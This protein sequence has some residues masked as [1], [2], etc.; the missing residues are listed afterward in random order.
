MIIVSKDIVKQ[1]YPERAAEAKKYDFGL[2]VA[3]GGSEF[4]SGPPALSALAGF[5]A[6]LDMA[7]II[8]PRRAADIIAGFSPILAAYPLEGDHLNKSHIAT[9]RSLTETAKESAHGNAAVVIGG[10]LGRSRETL[11]AVAEFLA[12]LDIPVVIDADAFYAIQKR[13]DILAG[14]PFLLTPNTYEFF[15]LTGKNVRELSHEER[16]E[17]VKTEAGKLGVTILLKLRQDIIS[18]G[19]EV[20]VNETGSPYLTVGG[21]G[22]TLAGI[23]AT[24]LA[25]GNM[26]F[27]AAQGAAYLNGRAG[28]IAA[29]KFGES[30]VA[31]DLIDALPSAI[32]E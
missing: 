28:E 13:L 10:G 7:R 1:L 26:P 30:L 21:T 14:K 16:M 22:D 25:R 5:R 27:V 20:A 18:D 2:M 11:D 17:L 31:A 23:A 6:G 15:L 32:R 24:L 8:A 4:Y 9:L 12:D 3:I 29:E 19:N